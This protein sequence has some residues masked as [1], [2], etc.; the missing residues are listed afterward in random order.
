MDGKVRCESVVGVKSG[1][2]CFEIAKGEN[3]SSTAFEVINPNL[4]CTALFIGQWI[5]ISGSVN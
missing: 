4:N 2:S 5:C 3:L 1:D